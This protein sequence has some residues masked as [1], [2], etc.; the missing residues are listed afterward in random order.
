[1]VHVV[2]NRVLFTVDIIN[3]E[4]AIIYKKLRSEVGKYYEQGLLGYEM[5]SKLVSVFAKYKHWS[6]F[7]LRI[8][9]YINQIHEELESDSFN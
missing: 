4:F 7:E 5:K 8:G 9:P 3:N 1:M 2:E 6:G